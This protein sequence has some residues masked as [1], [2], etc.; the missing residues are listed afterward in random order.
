MLVAVAAGL[1][2]AERGGEADVAAQAAHLTFISRAPL[3]L[4]SFHNI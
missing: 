4:L 3:L 1:A 2:E